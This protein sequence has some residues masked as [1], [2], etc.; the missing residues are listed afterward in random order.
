MINFNDNIQTIEDININTGHTMNMDNTQVYAVIAV[1]TNVPV[2]GAGEPAESEACYCICD[3]RETAEAVIDK[4][5][6]DGH[7][8]NGAWISP[9]VLQTKELV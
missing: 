8:Y 6:R 7:I 9:H 3:S 2:N 4:D 1:E 5:T